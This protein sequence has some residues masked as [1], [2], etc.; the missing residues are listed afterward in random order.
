MVRS[1]ITS[2]FAGAL[3]LGFATAA[4]AVTGEYGNMCSMGLALGK[5]IQTDCSINAQLQG[6]TYCFGSK[7]AMA[8]FMKDP[9]TNLAKAQAYYSKKHPG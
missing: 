5:D 9:T 6:K 8:E 2:A 3:L 1:Y 7:E 4:L